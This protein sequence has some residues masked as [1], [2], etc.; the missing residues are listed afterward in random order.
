[1]KRLFLLSVFICIPTLAQENQAIYFDGF[2]SVEFETK[3]SL[4]VLT[5]TANNEKGLSKTIIFKMGDDSFLFTTLM[6]GEYSEMLELDESAIRSMMPTLIKY[7]M[8][9]H[10]VTLEQ[11][12]KIIYRIY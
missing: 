5:F 9:R 7:Y 2:E 11:L 10:E 4:K 1:M 6:D 3:E 8:D 12:N